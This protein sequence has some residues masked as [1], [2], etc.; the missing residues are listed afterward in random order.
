MEPAIRAKLDQHLVAAYTKLYRTINGGMFEMN[1]DWVRGY[2]GLDIPTFNI[3]M[4]L[5][6]P[7]LS[8]DTLADTAAFFS[9]L[10]VMYAVEIIH[11][12][13]P[14]G[15]DFLTQRR[16]QPL[17]PQPALSLAGL[18]ENVTINPAVTVERI[19]TVPSLTALCSL[20]HWVFD[21]P[22]QDMAKIYSA[23]HLKE[24]NKHLF[25]HYVAF[26]DEKPVG[27]G[28]MV[29]VNGVASIS[30]LCTLDEYRRQR[31]ATTLLQQMLAEA[32]ESGCQYTTLFS[33]PLA[34]H[35]FMK[36]GFDLYAQRQWFLP[37]EVDFEEE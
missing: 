6:D 20:L 29:C 31:V 37:P 10:D 11:D 7:G 8:D 22:L 35:L 21:F 36:L 30:N 13:F 27:A 25:R 16:Y 33:T 2:S 5:T 23:A 28:S 18:P 19:N 32:V 1:S 34:F 15:P 3:F 9:S 12:R 24:E 26:M 4:P 17:P 14:H